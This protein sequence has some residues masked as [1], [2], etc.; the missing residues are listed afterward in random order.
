MKNNTI[1]LP[2]QGETLTFTGDGW[3]NA[4]E[5]AVAF[6]KRPVDWLA[7]DSTK[8]YIIVLANMLKCEKSSLLKT[9]RGKNGGGTWFHPKLAVRF[10]QWL[11]VKF[12][13]WCDL[14][15][16]DLLRGTHQTYDCRRLRHEAASSYKVMSMV[17][18]EKRLELGKETMPHHYMCEAKL[19]NYALTGEFKGVDR[20]SLDSG[21]LSLLAGL[22]TRNAALLGMGV[23]YADRKKLL[24]QFSLEWRQERKTKIGRA[25]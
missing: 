3:F 9:R 23:H 20:N 11:D 6:G 1:L 5:A 19:V 8:E 4:T 21:D 14:Q 25:A 18:L 17:L 12:A 10:A 16:D 24:E 22:E 2:Y 7:L 13:I 15:I